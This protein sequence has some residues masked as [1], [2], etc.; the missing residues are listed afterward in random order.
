MSENCKTDKEILTRL[1]KQQET[2]VKSTNRYDLRAKA[3]I[4]KPGD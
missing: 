1:K 3:N 2:Q 4:L